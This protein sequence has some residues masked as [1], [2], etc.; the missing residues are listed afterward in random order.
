MVIKNLRLFSIKARLIGLLVCVFFS[1]LL[2]LFLALK[3]NKE[4]IQQERFLKTQ[5]V[6]EVA[7][8][9][10]SHFYNLTV[11]GELAKAQAQK[12]A[13]DTIRD[14][15]YSQVEYFFI[16][17]YN[18]IPVMHP[19]VP[20][21]EGQDVK[22]KTD[23]NGLPI[24]AEITRVGKNEGQGF[25]KYV[26][27]KPGSEEPVP[28][29]AFVKGFDNWGWVI[30]S[31]VYLDDIDTQFYESAKFFIGV[32]LTLLCLTFALSYFIL[33]SIVTPLTQIQNTLRGIADGEGDLTITLSE[34]GNDQITSIARAYNR[35]T[36]R[37]SETLTHATSLFAQ[38]DNKSGDLKL[39][40][41]TALKVSEERADVFLSI[42]EVI[43][44]IKETET[45]VKQHTSDSL[46]L[47]HDAKSKA[48]ES[49]I[50]I[51]NTMK[52][53]QQLSDELDVSVKSVVQLESES[54][55]IGAVLDVISG[56]AEQT[57]LLALNAAIEA[58]RAGEHG[59]GFAVVADE[60]RGLA[61]R[62]QSSTEEIQSMINKLQKGASDAEHRITSGHEKFKLAAQ[63]ISLTAESLYSIITSVD[64]ISKTGDLIAS[65]VASQSGSINEL[66]HMNIKVASLSQTAASQNQENVHHCE[67][68]VSVSDNAKEVISTFKLN[69]E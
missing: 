46:S 54:Q 10:I 57:N 59:R 39:S 35:F 67:D 30:G 26:W 42:S 4:G 25:I 20:A 27:P 23:A 15:R 36:Q 14:M 8:D 32:C 12:F 47:A 69:K 1:I 5:N 37:L 63:E 43:D 28:K 16:Q 13:K 48:Q 3:S 68:L 22:D 11:T 24:F 53:T 7:H 40:A 41:E 19:I 18:A 2:I 49:R 62:T 52:T 6:V 66:S 17:D 29:V 58:A 65:S 38:V 31:G 33:K 56:I 45:H 64:E 44:Q 51:E 61:S 9:V 50:S 21:L 34:N 55:N 60:V